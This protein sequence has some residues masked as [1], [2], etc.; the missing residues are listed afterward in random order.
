MAVKSPLI[1]VIERAARKAGRNLNR[2]FGEVEQLQVRTKGPADFVSNADHKAEDI[3]REELSKARPDFGFLMEESGEI[4][5]REDG[6]RFIVDPLDGTTNFLHGVPH[7]CISIG[8]EGRSVIGGKLSSEI[9][10]GVVYD[11][12]HD[13]SYWAEKGQG[14]YLNDRRLRVSGRRDLATSLIASGLPTQDRAD[15]EVFQAQMRALMD[16]VAGIRRFGVAALDLAWT[17]AGRFDAFW[18]VALKPWDVAAGI[19]LVREAGGFVSEI[20]GGNDMLYGGSILAS[21]GQIHAEVR[22]ILAKAR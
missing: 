22:G 6:Y 4:K 1:N 11:P 3:I 9:L 2:D 5:G 10:A 19:L 13:H 12:V 15:P 17:A 14:A 7:F 18:E 16:K 20:D 8:V 21:N